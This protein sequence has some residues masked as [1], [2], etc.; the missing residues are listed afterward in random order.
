MSE[1]SSTSDPPAGNV[2]VTLIRGGWVAAWSN[3]HHHVVH[4]GE[5][6]FQGD[7]IIY[8]G[9][10]YDGRI[11]QVFDRPEWFVCPGFINLHGHI[12][13][14]LLAQV[15]D[16]GHTAR[17]SPSWEFVSSS[18]LVL[19]RSLTTKEQ[20][21][22]AEFSLVQMLKC[23]TTTVVDVGGSGPI[24]WLGNAPHDEEML[25]DTVGQIGCRAYLA[26]AYRSGRV[27]QNADHSW[28]WHPAEEL[29]LAGLSSAVSFAQRYRGAYGGRVQTMLTPHAV[30]IAS[31][32]LLQATLREARVA[33]LLIQIHAAQYPFEVHYVRE[34]YGE[35]PIGYLARLGFL[36]SDIILG[37]CV[38]TSGHPLVGGDPD[39]DLDLISR[40]GSSVAHAPLTFARVGEGLYSLPRYLDHGINVGIGCDIWPADII[41]EMRLAWQAGKL[42]SGSA[43]RPTCME[44]FHAAT[45]G[46]AEALKRSD[47]GRLAPGALADIVCVD[48]SAYHYGPVADPVRALVTCGTGQDIDTVF[49]AGNKIVE[50]GRVL[51]SDE[52]ELRRAA[53]SILA[54]MAAVASDRDPLHRTLAGILGI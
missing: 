18:P 8:V 23:G 40:S 52:D 42:L 29:G 50:Q 54:N 14:E 9:A 2:P 19:P 13:L 1:M 20:R 12:G 51:N 28:G 26:L 33:K 39:R 35:T 36:G 41:A 10:K 11:D 3:G 44:V 27:Y 32:A 6:A 45:V 15:V 34:Q 37:H 31:P 22:S 43:E 49:V 30:D 21:L 53:P 25:V 5:V 16:V 7:H 47:L 46:S 4:S 17:F 24:W 38:Y 48:L